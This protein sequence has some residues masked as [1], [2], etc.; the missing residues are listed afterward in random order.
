[1]IFNAQMKIRGLAVAAA[2]AISPLL[3]RG[4]PSGINPRV[5]ESGGTQM[6][7]EAEK[8]EKFMGRWSRRLAP[9]FVK[10]AGVGD[11]ERMLDVGSGTGPLALVIAG[12]TR[13]SEVVGIDPSR[14]YVDFANQRTS[15]PRIKFQ[16]GDAQKLDFPSGTFDRCLSLLVMN[17]IPDARKAMTEMCRVTKPG[18]WVAA[19]VWDYSDGMKMLRI[20]W[21][22]VGAIDPANPHDES[23]MPLCRKGQLAALWREVGLKDVEE[24]ELVIDMQFTSFEDYWAPFL[25]AQGP[26][27]V[28]VTN[29]SQERREQLKNNLRQTILAGKPDGPF[30]LKARAWA[31]RGRVVGADHAERG[32]RTIQIR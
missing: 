16:V 28:Y 26:A 8:Y 30:S 22:A 27:G 15:D 23:N 29:L 17:F 13:Q 32:L 2:I 14:S 6:F 19:C 12:E 18:G 3:A 10:F 4:M 9:L 25:E 21:D 20:F 31:V 7:S 24:K 11:G 5:E 1:M